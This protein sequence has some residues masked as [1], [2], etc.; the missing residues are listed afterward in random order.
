[1]RLLGPDGQPFANALIQ[2]AYDSP[3]AGTDAEGRFTLM[4]PPGREFHM[5][6]VKGRQ[7]F[8]TDVNKLKIVPGEIKDLGDVHYKEYQ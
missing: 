8:D 5:G 3:P 2:V 7:E 4:V 6:G 1:G